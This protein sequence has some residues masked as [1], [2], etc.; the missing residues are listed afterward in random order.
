VQTG[1]SRIYKMTLGSGVVLSLPIALLVAWYVWAAWADVDR[2]RRAQ[3]DPPP[4]D[5]ELFQ[6]ALHDQLSRDWRRFDLPSRPADSTLRTMEISLN[7]ENLDL[8]AA[9]R[10]KKDGAA[11]YADA[12][13][14]VGKSTY[15]VKV[16]Y[17]GGQHWHWIGTQ[18]S[19]KVRV[20]GDLIDGTRVFNL[21]NDVTPFGLEEEIVLDYAREAGLLTPEYFPVWVRLNNSDMGVY[22]YEAQP[23]EGLLRRHR[24]M[25]GSMFSGDSEKRSPAGA[26]GL[27]WDSAGWSKVAWEENRQEDRAQVDRLLHAVTA[28]TQRE[29]ADYAR[30]EIDIEKYAMFDALDVVFGGN[31]HDWFSNHKIYVDPYRGKIEP[32]AWA[33]RAFQNEPE[34]NLVENPLLLRLK[35]TPGYLSRRNRAVYELLAG[36]AAVPEVRARADRLFLQLAPDLDADP[37]WD[38]Y[39]LLPRATRYHRFMV[40]PMTK[41]RWLLSAQD[42]LATYA[43]RSRWLLD[44]FER[45]G[46][47]VEPG[48]RGALG[49]VRVRV[50]G[51]AAFRLRSATARAQCSGAFELFADDDRDGRLDRTRDTLVAAGPLGG[52][53]PAQGRVDLEAGVRFL[54]REDSQP[55]QGPVT[56]ETDPRLYRYF[57]SAPC[58]PYSIELEL[59]NL[60]TGGSRR[61]FVR[62]N[63]APEETPVVT[64]AHA[65]LVPAFQP[66]EISAHPWEYPSS[67]V[68]RE[69]RLGPGRVVVAET[70]TFGATESVRIESG[71]EIALAEGAALVFRGR[72]SIR[73]TQVVPLTPGK[74]HG[75]LVLE[76]PGTAGSTI[77]HLV[78]D[79]G[80]KPA[81]DRIRYTAVI[82]IYDTRDVTL[83]HVRITGSTGVD[84]VLH[85]AYVDGLK[86]DDVRIQ[87]SPSD[88]IDLE[89]VDGEARRLVVTGA[90]DDCLDL[91]GTSL[92]LDDSV[93]AGCTNNGISA[94]EESS[95]FAHGV[96]LAD[97]K[98]GVLAKNASS[99]QLLRSLVYRAGAALETNRRD[100]HYSGRSSIGAQDLSVV[101]CGS[102]VDAAASTTVDP[103][104]VNGTL[105]GSGLE[106]LRKEVLRIR[107]WDELPGA[108]AAGRGAP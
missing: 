13:V 65:G 57:V 49:I 61:H 20:E 52:A 73:G 12:V 69:I 77:S 62:I 14:R 21:L 7:R 10:K 34:L 17:R 48:R 72:V 88:G 26:G 66:G 23:E 18:Q 74:P 35:M 67:P 71:T 64:V 76:G 3:K 101:E 11:G 41:G 37:Y 29:F 91:M 9:T 8:L 75:G 36:R 78:V 19:M 53:A 51:D 97:A 43:R 99:V 59:D 98:S 60:T 87:G 107:T 63:G 32:I 54:E 45:A 93:L 30:E 103:G 4:L 33:F 1:F 105:E 50:D 46:I 70:R 22:R 40:R 92:R 108:L 83:E 28:S 31:D 104:F 102:V 44:R 38:A 68:P 86:L 24:R 106:Y 5:A 90:G 95:V 79:G 16:R 56:A 27:F 15:P 100:V 89:F 47:T 39:K 55:R 2:Y 80:T 82:S 58:D 25:P 42:E 84:D 85:A 96:L 81:S 94:G 6:I